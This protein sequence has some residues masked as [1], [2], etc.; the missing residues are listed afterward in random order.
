MSKRIVDPPGGWKYGFPMELPE[1]K[2]YE[3]LLRENGYPEE[4]MELAL[5][6]TRQWYEE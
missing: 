2:S 3:E 1:G 4:D 6:W 5:K